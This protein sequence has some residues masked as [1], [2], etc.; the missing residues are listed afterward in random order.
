MKKILY[1]Q[2]DYQCTISSD[3]NF[4]EIISEHWTEL[5][6]SKNKMISNFT[7]EINGENWEIF[8]PNREGEIFFASSVYD[9][10]SKYNVLNGLTISY[11]ST[12][13]CRTLIFMEVTGKGF[14]LMAPPDK[15]GRV[16]EFRI[17]AED[18]KNVSINIKGE[19]LEW[20][21]LFFK[22]L[23]DLEKKVRNLQTAVPWSGLSA[24]KTNSNWQVQVGLIGP[25]EKT[26]VPENSGFNV[27]V[28]ISKLMLRKLGENNILH[29]FGYSKGHDTGYPDYSPS[30]QLGG[31]SGLEKSI[32]AIHQNR[33][34][35][36]F[37][38]NGRIAQKE[39]V[40]KDGLYN[41]V[42][43]DD[44]NIPFTEVYHTRDFYVM[45]PLSEEWQTRLLLEA[46][47]LKELGADGIQ[48]DQLGGRAAPVPAGDLWGKGYINLINDLHKE[49]LTVWIQGL[50]DIYPADWFELTYRDTNILED[51]TIRGGTPLGKPEKCI[52]QISVPN[53]VLLIPF[54][55]M[56]DKKDFNN[57]RIITDLD[58][59]KGELFLYNP[60]YMTQL[61]KLMHKAVL[62]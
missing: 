7:L 38:M 26:D 48:L 57:N 23:K 6:L 14:A 50:S 8:W 19:N 1:K 59:N 43:T 37:Y 39:N 30:M 24:V 3:F 53:Q 4:T 11:P 45:N 54:S 41:S 42:L 58:I 2:A 29:V 12:A 56:E 10:I 60:L 5:K 40:E 32:N 46:M 49:G 34:K 15:K 33:Q 28:D 21:S 17:N 62:N 18:N 36:V 13:S 47:K 22:S 51:G 16:T 55:K 9:R 44:N 61:E 35:V 27:L 25:D 20:Y 31:R 52:F